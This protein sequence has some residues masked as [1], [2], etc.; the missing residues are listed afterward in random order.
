MRF[1]LT[2]ISALLLWGCS[3]SNDSAVTVDASGK[4][5][6]GW[7]TSHGASY[8][9][10]TAT[11]AGCHGASLTGGISGVSCSSSSFNG[12]SCHANGPHPIPWSA[13]NLATNQLNG[14]SPCHGAALAGGARAP[15]CTKCHTQLL[16]GTVPLLGTCIS[17]HTNPPNGA[18]FP[19]ISGAHQ[20]HLTLPLV[21]CPVCHSGAG[22]GTAQHGKG[23]LVAFPANYNAKTGAAVRNSDGSCANVS[24]HGGIVTKPWRGGRV[25]PLVECGGCHTA[26]SAAGVPQSNSYYS[27]EHGKHLLEIGLQ[28]VDCHD[29]SVVSGGVAHFSGLGTAAFELAPSATLRAPL[30]YNAGAR[31]CSPG[32]TPPAGSFSIGVCHGTKTW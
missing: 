5:P 26:G 18:V 29:M 10:N 3:S 11:C 27:G 4:H 15:A 23:L 8:L 13:H 6:S 2:I 24:C 19:N 21:G 16:P 25:N 20:A 32:S 14:C 31:N 1:L 7:V 17:C 28:C 22:S 12:L 9:Q 30:S